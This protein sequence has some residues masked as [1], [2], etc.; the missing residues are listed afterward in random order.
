MQKLNLSLILNTTAAAAAAVDDDD[1]DDNDSRYFRL[2]FFVSH[3]IS[4]ET[5]SSCLST[6]TA[7]YSQSHNATYLQCDT[8]I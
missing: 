3:K 5:D 6:K 4:S 2:R 8:A 7:T 1:D